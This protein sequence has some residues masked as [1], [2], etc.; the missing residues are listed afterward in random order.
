MGR[1]TFPQ[2]SMKIHGLQFFFLLGYTF[3]YGWYWHFILLYVLPHFVQ[4]VSKKS[5]W[6]QN[7]WMNKEALLLGGYIISNGYSSSS[8]NGSQV[9]SYYRAIVYVAV[10]LSDLSLKEGIIKVQWTSFKFMI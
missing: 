5:K 3:F 9:V 8:V 1:Y 6:H 2:K 10:L 7:E 4:K